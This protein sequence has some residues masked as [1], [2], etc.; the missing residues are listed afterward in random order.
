MS[1]D[2][3]RLTEL[4][5]EDPKRQFFS[6]AHLITPEKM[7][8]AFRNLRKEA[9]AGVDGVTHEEYERDAAGNIRQLHRR[10][11]SPRPMVRGGGETP[12][13]GGS[14]RDPLCG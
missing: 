10:L 3:D 11:K 1:T 7:L 2:I 5:K 6:I 13:K 14:L 12:V 8:A 9:S 4:A